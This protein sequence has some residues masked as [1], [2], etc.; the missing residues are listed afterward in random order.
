MERRWFVINSIA[1][2]EPLCIVVGVSTTS[3]G[4]E[5]V[6]MYGDGLSGSPERVSLPYTVEN[7]GVHKKDARSRTLLDLYGQFDAL[8]LHVV[9][10]GVWIIPSNTHTN[11]HGSDTRKSHEAPEFNRKTA[12]P[13]PVCRSSTQ[14]TRYLPN[15]RP[16]NLLNTVT[17]PQ[18]GDPLRVRTVFDFS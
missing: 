3:L 4:P 15:H 5:I 13:Y 12:Y 18:L 9:S 17:Q 10:K 2:H 7:L 14:P 16:Y 1:L 8:F 6:L 11:Y